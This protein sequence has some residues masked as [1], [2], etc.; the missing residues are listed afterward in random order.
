MAVYWGVTTVRVSVVVVS[1]LCVI[2]VTGCGGPGC[3]L[4]LSPAVVVQAVPTVVSWPCTTVV[5]WPVHPQ[6]CPG[7]CTTV[8]SWPVYHKWCPG[9]GAWLCVIT[10]RGGGA[11]LFVIT[12]RGWCLGRFG[13]HCWA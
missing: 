9:G 12:V 4:L 13:D 7:P 6:L 1:W 5:P 8:V 3:V 2:A 11:W 10:V